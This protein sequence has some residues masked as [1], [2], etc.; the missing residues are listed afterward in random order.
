MVIWGIVEIAVSAVGAYNIAKGAYNMYCDAE[1]IKNQY[2]E[3]QRTTEEYRRAQSL[4]PS[5][6]LTE[7]QYHRYEGEFMVLNQSAIIDPYRPPPERRS[8]QQ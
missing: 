7:S 1:V 8:E 2:R 3:H 6:P 5:D 4:A